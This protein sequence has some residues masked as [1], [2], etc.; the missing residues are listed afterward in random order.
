M[1]S[2]PQEVVAENGR[3]LHQSRAVSLQNTRQRGVRNDGFHELYGGL[4][5]K[6]GDDDGDGARNERG[7]Y[8]VLANL[9]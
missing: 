2:I 3:F 4:F 8:I 6:H 5:G 7:C 9:L 1:Q